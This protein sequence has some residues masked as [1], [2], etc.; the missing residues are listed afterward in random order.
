MSVPSLLKVLLVDD[1]PLA[2]L[3][4]R[5]LLEGCVDPRAEVLAEAG[6]ASQA[7]AWLREHRCDLILLDV[8]MPGPDGLQ[9]AG[10]LRA[11]AQQGGNSPAVVFVTAHAEHA[12]Q[13]FELEA[14][15]YLSKPVRRERLQAALL[16]VAQRLAERA[17]M[18]AQP[19]GRGLP[20]GEPDGVIN[21]SDRGRLLRVPLAEV[22]YFKAE[23]KYLT[24]RTAT[25]SLVMDGSLSDLEPRLGERFLRVHRNA[26]V[27]KAAVRE[28]QRHAVS[29][30]GEDE[31]NSDSADGADG[32]AVRIAGVNEWLAVSRRQVAAVREALAGQGG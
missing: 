31:A 32:W 23:L 11:Q 13:A 12:L 4:L 9:L 27:A 8:Q 17:A 14:T 3:R 26:L 25:Q 18:Q 15:D 2:R 16:R 19:E 6:S 30:A 20:L 28:L 21:V 22:L 10:A 7:Q 1:E 5:S 24:L 29:H